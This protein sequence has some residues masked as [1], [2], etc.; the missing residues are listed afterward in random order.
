MSGDAPLKALRRDDCFD[1]VV[2]ACPLQAHWLDGRP[3]TDVLA[4]AGV[5]DCYRRLVV[6]GTPV[7][8]GHAP[9]GDAWACTNP[10][11]G[12]GLSVGMA[13]AQHLRATVREHLDDP[14]D[15]TRAYDEVTER[16]VAPFYRNQVAADR[17]RLA[18]MDAIREGREP[19]PLDPRQALLLTA[20]MQDPE[21]F[22]GLME[23]VTCLALPQEV[24]SRPGM[25]E[26][27][28]GFAGA[29]PPPPMP[30]PDRGRLLDLLAG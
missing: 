14:A 17:V 21:V 1:R 8:T 6:D 30:G 12:R 19:P 24:L 13:H 9:V 23:I 4:M 15:F 26:R 10:S 7:V 20:A 2:R 16:E 5:L 22:R 25:Q 27:L 18:E 11:A 28:A 29:P 3:I